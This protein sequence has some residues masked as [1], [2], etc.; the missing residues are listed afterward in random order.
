M[1]GLEIHEKAVSASTSCIEECRK[2]Y[3]L[4][5]KQYLTGKWRDVPGY[6]K[7]PFKKYLQKEFRLTEHKLALNLVLYTEYIDDV[8]NHGYDIVYTILKMTSHLGD[9]NRTR[10]TILT[11]VRGYSDLKRKQEVVTKWKNKLGQDRKRISWKREA[12]LLMDEV[13]KLRKENEELRER[14]KSAEE[15]RRQVVNNLKEQF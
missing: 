15:A 3:N 8:Y 14:V 5:K 1:T 4:I 10:Q 2:K 9:G 7:K 11:E 13:E 12:F 6:R